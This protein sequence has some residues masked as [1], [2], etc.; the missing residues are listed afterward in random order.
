MGNSPLSTEG[1]SLLTLCLTYSF[2][3]VCFWLHV[4]GQRGK[5]L[6][7]RRVDATE[8]PQPMTNEGL[9]DT[10]YLCPWLE[11]LWGMKYIISQSPQWVWAAV[12]L[13]PF[14]VENPNY[15]QDKS[16]LSLGIRQFP[17]SL[18]PLLCCS[19]VCF[20]LWAP[21]PADSFL[22]S[23]GVSGREGSGDTETNGYPRIRQ[24]RGIRHFLNTCCEPGTALYSDLHKGHLLAFSWQPWVERE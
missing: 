15:S 9:A 19:C 17:P 23:L 2:L 12:S 6:N 21:Y 16:K 7:W 10:L 24:G 14:F 1:Y 11:L 22:Q 4:L 18:L 13:L 5:N 20:V 8:S 3:F